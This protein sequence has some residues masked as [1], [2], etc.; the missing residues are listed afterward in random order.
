MEKEHNLAYVSKLKDDLENIFI[1]SFEAEID[2]ALDLTQSWMVNTPK[3]SFIRLRINK[4]LSLARCRM[5]N[6]Y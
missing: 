6:F 5:D 4:I 3:K 1:P 2:M